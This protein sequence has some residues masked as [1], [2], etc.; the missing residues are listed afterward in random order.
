MTM[1]KTRINS[2][3]P[4]PKARTAARSPDREAALAHHWLLATA[5]AILL[6]VILAHIG[7]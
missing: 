4:R 2:T 1:L 5:F 7:S 3:G 6:V